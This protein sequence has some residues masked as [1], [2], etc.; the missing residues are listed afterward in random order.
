MVTVPS[1]EGAWVIPVHF[2]EGSCEGSCPDGPPFEACCSA[3][4]ITGDLTGSGSALSLDQLGVRPARVLSECQPP[5][6]PSL[7]A[8]WGSCGC[9]GKELD[10]PPPAQAVTL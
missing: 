4:Q 1:P 8:P 6:D 5:R 10:I 3:A 7:E 2:H 9:G